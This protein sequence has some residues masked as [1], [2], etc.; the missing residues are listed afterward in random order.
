MFTFDL[1][2]EPCPEIPHM[3]SATIGM[4]DSAGKVHGCWIENDGVAKV[5]FWLDGKPVNV[6]V[7][8]EVGK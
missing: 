2:L 8:K 1:S 4:T 7:K 3:Y 5:I 6:D